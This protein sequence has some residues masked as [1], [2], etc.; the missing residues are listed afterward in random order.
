MKKWIAAAAIVW[1]GS[2]YLA[3]GFG[4]LISGFTPGPVSG[5]ARTALSAMMLLP[6]S[7]RPCDVEDAMTC[8]FADT[9]GRAELA[10]DAFA[11]DNPERAVLFAFG[12]S[13]SA[14]A[15]RDR[16]VP[17]HDVVNFNAHDGKCYRAEDPL[18]GPSGESG[19]VWGRV[20]DELIREGLYRQVLIVPIGIGGTEL[21]RWVPGADLHARIKGTAAMLR[22]L[23]IRPTH[24][25]WHQ[26]ESD[27][28]EDTAEEDYVA[29]FRALADSLP[30]LGIDAPVL[31]AIAT[32][33]DIWGNWPEYLPSAERVRSA[34]QSL[35][36]RVANVRPGPDT[37]TI[38]G[39]RFRP[40]GCH[41]TH[42]GIAAHARL[43]V[44]AIRDAAP[45]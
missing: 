37:D 11:G 31:P 23:D 22:R 33:C 8:G 30:G 16:Y 20:G 4:A 41:F 29:Q 10:C 39:P 2:L 32:H 34:Q 12:Q 40:D 13:N 35:P 28:F 42:R 14:N 45:E 43:W 26:G 44:R 3:Y 19:S 15:A 6:G 9:E 7:A 1:L 18:L 24:V 17:L 5:A 21:A 27:V 36:Q 38:A 25:L